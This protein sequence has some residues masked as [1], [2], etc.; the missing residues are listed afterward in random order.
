MT[1][2]G[3]MSKV[4]HGRQ[5]HLSVPEEWPVCGIR[6]YEIICVPSE[7]QHSPLVLLQLG[8]ETHGRQNDRGRDIVY[9]LETHLEIN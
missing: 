5:S 3:G 8:L 2:I 4:S 7:L 9:E 6:R 1:R